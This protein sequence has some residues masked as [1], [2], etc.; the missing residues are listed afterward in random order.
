[1]LCPSLHGPSASR[2]FEGHG[3]NPSLHRRTSPLTTRKARCV[4]C[5]FSI[6]Q[7]L[8]QN[9][10]AA[11]VVRFSISSSTCAQSARP[12]SNTCRRVE[13]GQSPCPHTCLSALRTDIKSSRTTRKPVYQVGEFYTPSAEAVCGITTLVWG[14]HGPSWSR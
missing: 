2:S 12:T 6:H 11:R 7:Q 8:R 14:F 1:M 4:A 10:Y 13:R 5:T 3:S 9:S